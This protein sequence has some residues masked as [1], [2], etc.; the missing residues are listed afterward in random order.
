MV[1]GAVS[2]AAEFV[3]LVD[4][5]DNVLGSE[6]KLR[7]H[8]DG[9]LHR[10]FSIFVFDRDR[11]LLLQRRSLHK[12]HSASLWSNTCCGHP[13]P[14]EATGAAAARRLQEEMG[15]TCDLYP[16]FRTIYRAALPGSMVEHELDQVLVGRF[17]GAPSPDPLE[18]DSFVRL[19]ID[20]LRQQIHTAPEHFTAWLKLLLMCDEWPRV[21]ELLNDTD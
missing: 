19:S 6:A 16:A 13:R 4:A 5:D 10:A 3:T 17:D 12:Y 11:R 15:F 2:D 14:G 1:D 20:E 7:A 8:R 18:V 21:A 9:T